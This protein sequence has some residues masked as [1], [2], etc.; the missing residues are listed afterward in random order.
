MPNSE[1]GQPDNLEGNKRQKAILIL[2]SEK[3]KKRQLCLLKKMFLCFKR[4]GAAGVGVLMLN[5]EVIYLTLTI[6]GKFILSLSTS[7]TV[8]FAIYSFSSDFQ[9]I[10]KTLQQI[11]ML[12][13]KLLRGTIKSNIKIFFGTLCFS[14]A[15]HKHLCFNIRQ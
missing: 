13:L 3:K 1:F 7:L 4:R 10:K 8:I 6:K 2:N 15:C 14:F 9:L 12:C 11:S 5:D